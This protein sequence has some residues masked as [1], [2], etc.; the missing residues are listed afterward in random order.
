MRRAAFIALAALAA[1]APLAQAQRVAG[2]GEVV[3][4]ASAPFRVTTFAGGLE[5][6]WGA[7]FLPDGSL[8]VTER[9]GR[10]R[11]L[12]PDGTLSEPLGNVPEV[13]AAGQGGLLDVQV[14]PDF[15]TTR[16]IY[17]CHAVLVASP[18]RGTT[19]RL[20]RARLS[21]DA[22]RL[23]YAQPILDALP[24]DR[25]SRS[26]YGCRIAFDAD[27]KL[28]LSTGERQDK[29]RAQKLDDLAGKV[30]RL[31]RDGRPADGNPFLGRPGVR[32]EIFTY[33]HRNPQG[34]ARNP[35]TGAMWE[36]EFGAR[37]GDEVNLLRPGLNYGWPVVAYGTNYDGSRIGEGTSRP[38]MEEPLRH[39]VPAV[40]PSGIGFYDGDAF[41]AWKGSLFM[42]S[43]NTP[44]L[45]RLSTEG[46]RITGE[47]RLL[48]GELRFRHVLQG[49][50]G[51]IYL[52]T[53]E[54]RGRILRLEPAAR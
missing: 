38:D 36:A 13:L 41:P 39:W 53:D 30:L 6:P 18:A 27:G 24:V 10:L 40:S 23:D 50:D 47:E 8:L 31:E 15:A 32:P 3:R 11:L 33:G 28:Y 5:R 16:E 9:P 7:A 14:A 34:L 1:C 25:S 48:W 42:A 51:L 20:A 49:P 4:Q 26:H 52:L 43:L 37:G 17:L 12:A 19:T 45:I 35:W 22:T 46:D 29:P 54:T 44:G 21:P 2:T